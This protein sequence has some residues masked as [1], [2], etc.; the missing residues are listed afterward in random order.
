M[1]HRTPIIASLAAA[2][3]LIATFA[4]A[5]PPRQDA[6]KQAPPAEPKFEVDV[7]KDPF[8]EGKVPAEPAKPKGGVVVAD[9]VDPAAYAIVQRA[10]KVAA[11]LR[12]IELVTS[13]KLEG[14]DL[15]NIPAGYGAPHE[16]TLEYRFKDA[17]SLPKMRI[18]PVSSNG[19]VVFTHNG[20]GGLVV[21]MNAKV[22]RA[23]K[24]GW[25]TL[26]PFA[27]GALPGWITTERQ[28]A[29]SQGKKSS[30]V[31]LRPVL[32]AASILRAETVDGVE[33][34]VVRIVK[35]RDLFAD[36]VGGGKPG[37]VDVQ[38]IVQEVAYARADG[39]PR[40][41]IQ[42]LDGAPEGGQR[43]TIEFSRVKV[44][45]TLDPL[46]FD[47]APPAGFRELSATNPASTPPAGGTK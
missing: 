40:R 5:E 31:E 14:G 35:S 23:A 26:A 37:V 9:V 25:T 13:A 29:A 10:M 46:T 41:I 22:Y 19:V 21:D 8:V 45:P 30:E 39:F 20:S 36:D 44:N 27:L 15:T 6:P 12:T 24:T 18:S 33:C 43:S 1:R 16:V 38:R 2:T 3:V 4:S 17:I 34:D 28:L 7:P 11:E 42:T 47:I 32:I